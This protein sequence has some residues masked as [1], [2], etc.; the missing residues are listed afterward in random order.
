MP[1]DRLAKSIERVF[2][3]VVNAVGVDVNRMLSHKYAAASLRFVSGLGV[4]KAEYLLQAIFRKVRI[5]QK[6]KKG[7][8]VNRVGVFICY[9]IISF[10]GPIAHIQRRALE[11]RGQ[12][13][14]HELR[15]FHQDSRQALLQRKP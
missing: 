12:V 10:P 7:G 6:Q 1:A 14:V 4:R 8:R 11:L 13:R 9:L 15:R 5:E 3:N 2:I